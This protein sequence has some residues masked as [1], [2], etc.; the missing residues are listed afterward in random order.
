MRVI[1][2]DIADKINGKQAIVVEGTFETEKRK[3]GNGKRIP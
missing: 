2:L 1:G 3:R